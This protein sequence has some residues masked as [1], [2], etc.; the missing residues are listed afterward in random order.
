M[1]FECLINLLEEKGLVKIR[2]RKYDSICISVTIHSEYREVLDKIINSLPDYADYNDNGD[3]ITI[4]TEQDVYDWVKQQ[5]KSKGEPVIYFKLEHYF[6]YEERE[7]FKTIVKRIV[8]FEY[9]YQPWVSKTVKLTDIDGLAQ[10]EKEEE[11]KHKE[12]VDF[13]NSLP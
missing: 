10:I 12:V 2:R 8:D 4:M 13:L 5:M 6:L 9:E 3:R 7:L 11:R 1:K